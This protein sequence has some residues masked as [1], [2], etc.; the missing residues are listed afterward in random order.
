MAWPDVFNLLPVA[1]PKFKMCIS[2]ACPG[3][4]KLSFAALQ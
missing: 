2:L 4:A 1:L 3:L